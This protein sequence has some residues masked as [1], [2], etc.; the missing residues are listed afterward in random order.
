MVYVIIAII[1]IYLIY[2]LITKVI[3]PLIPIMLGLTVVGGFIASIVSYIRSISEN[4]YSYR[5]YIDKDPHKP[6]GAKRNYF[7]GPAQYQFR[8]IIKKAWYINGA[9][10][11]LMWAWLFENINNILLKIFLGFFIVVAT[12]VIAIMGGAWT[13]VFSVVHS[14]LLFP[15][16]IIFRIL[17]A[18]FAFIDRLVLAVHSISARCPD[19]KKRSVIPDFVCPK[20]GKV[21]KHLTPGHY[22]ILC[23]KCSCGAMLP[24]NFLNGRSRLESRC[25]HCGR[26]L[27]TSNARNFGIQLVGGT[28]SGKTTFLAAFI[29]LYLER[30]KKNKNI[31]ISLH[32]ESEFAEM[33]HWYSQGSSKTTSTMNAAMYSIAHTWKG[34]KFSHLFSIYD[35]AGEVFSNESAS[36]EQEQYRYCEGIIIVVDPFSSRS[37]RILYESEHEGK[38]LPNYSTSDVQ[39]VVTGFISEFSRISILSVGKVSDIP[40]SV[41]INKA[42]VD[43]VKREI[44]YDKIDSVYRINTQRY[45]SKDE[46]RDAVCKDY[47]CNIGMA[48]MV[49]NMASQFSKIHYFPV[50]AMG[51]EIDKA[52]SYDPWGVMEPVMWIIKKRD[53]GLMDIWEWKKKRVKDVIRGITAAAVT[54][55]ILT[56]AISF[57]SAHKEYFSGKAE[58]LNAFVSGKAEALNAFVSVKTAALKG[59]VSGKFAKIAEYRMPTARVISSAL[60]MRSESSANGAIIKTLKKGDTLTVTGE[61]ADGWTPVT[62]GDDSGWVSSRYII[63]D[64]IYTFH[65]RPVGTKGG[66][67]AGG[68][69][70]K[71]EIANGNMH[72]YLAS[73]PNGKG[74]KS[75]LSFG[76]PSTLTIQDL[77]NSSEKYSAITGAKWDKETGAYIITFPIVTS[78]RFTYI[79]TE[80]NPDWIIKEIIMDDPDK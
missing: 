43:M 56:G 40:V 52:E 24:S 28:K 21:S 4:K 76:P 6:E 1:G 69:L 78:N 37:L 53:Q 17:F 47:L 34:S 79:E 36:Q 25:P 50:S 54:T 73:S 10:I 58:A 64:G 61:T 29:H 14:M 35:I 41:I 44:G 72:L 39:E 75:K 63:K 60:N 12:V 19:C 27:P 33:E 22:G 48:G 31:H 46:A 23:R 20:C 67:E 80:P 38:I 16:I 42:D 51:H 74:E 65:P 26:V 9:I 55:L 32:P 8:M 7:F 30:M 18:I 15:F 62:H 66:K 11:L 49:N 70:V 45:K 5:T 77:N 57:Y 2:P 59:Y 3:I 68:W 13:V 71:I